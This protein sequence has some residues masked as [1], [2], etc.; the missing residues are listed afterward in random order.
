MDSIFKNV[1]GTYLA[2]F[3]PLIVPII[4]STFAKASDPT[5]QKLLKVIGT[6]VEMNL[7]S[8]ELLTKVQDAIGKKILNRSESMAQLQGL[9]QAYESR[10][11]TLLGKR[12]G[13]LSI[14]QRP[15]KAAYVIP[16]HPPVNIPGSYLE[17]QLMQVWLELERRIL[18]TRHD[19]IPL[20]NLARNKMAANMDI[21]D[22]LNE[23]A[24]ALSQPPVNV[25]GYAPPVLSMY[26]PMQ[27]NQSRAGELSVAAEWKNL[28][29]WAGDKVSESRHTTK[30]KQAYFPQK[31]SSELLADMKQS[32]ESAVWRLYQ[33]MKL[34]CKTCGF[35]CQSDKTMAKHMDYHF[36]VNR[37]EQF[38]KGNKLSQQWYE[39]E[40][41]WISLTP[42][43]IQTKIEEQEVVETKE[44]IKFYPEDPDR[45][46]CAFCDE[47]FEKI[48]NEEQEMWMFSGVQEDNGRLIHT[49]CLAVDASAK[50]KEVAAAVD[51][52]QEFLE[53]NE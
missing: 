26:P 6:W 7:F 36:S 43:T 30:E 23:I 53:E 28:S 52:D 14:P 3:A 32:N 34:Q 38:K 50:Y 41:D 5:R 18:S 27:Q 49:L 8:K 9:R 12:Y 16:A 21:K 31:S 19:L 35:R 15:T 17:P 51:P 22:S 4:S 37:R 33:S 44:E 20:L 10:T 13:E 24:F 45:K 40:D 42:L 2:S 47:E 25:A 46:F 11:G 29:E 1:G 48:W 39:T